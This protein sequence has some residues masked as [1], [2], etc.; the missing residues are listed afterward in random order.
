M[1]NIP[2]TAADTVDETKK[3]EKT[4]VDRPI[5]S[6]SMSPE[7]YTHLKNQENIDPDSIFSD[8][9]PLDLKGK[10]IKVFK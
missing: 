1:S 6:W 4:E 9:P 7:L 2:T 10:E 5:P 8:I 3:S